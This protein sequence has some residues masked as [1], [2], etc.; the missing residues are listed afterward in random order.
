MS[1]MFYAVDLPSHP[2]LN[3][4]PGIAF[5]ASLRQRDDTSVPAVQNHTDALPP[6]HIAH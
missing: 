2:F 6:Y 4:L 1:Q 5:I 3:D